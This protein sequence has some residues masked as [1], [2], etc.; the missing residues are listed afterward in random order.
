MHSTHAH[1]R[2]CRQSCTAD[3]SFACHRCAM[4]P[5]RIGRCRPS[6]STS[7]RKPIITGQEKSINS[8]VVRIFLSEE[9]HQLVFHRSAAGN[10]SGGV[11]GSVVLWKQREHKHI[12]VPTRKGPRK[13]NGFIKCS[14]S[15]CFQLI[16]SSTSHRSNT[17]KL[18]PYMCFSIFIA[19]YRFGQIVASMITTTYLS[20]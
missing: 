14:G 9:R 16:S 18:S 3:S 13:L 12:L 7:C 20:D 10:N 17:Q 4:N 15:S 11:N 2:C 6:Q 5:E 1:F 19:E 8:S